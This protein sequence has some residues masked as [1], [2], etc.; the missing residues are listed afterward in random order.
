MPVSCPNCGNVAKF[1]RKY[2]GFEQILM[3]K[4]GK[5]VVTTDRK[6]RV[7]EIT[8]GECSYLEVPEKFGF[9]EEEGM[10]IPNRGWWV[11]AS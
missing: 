1:F 8:C 6:I 10:S 4:D 2:I 3:N 7:I 5:V 9:E 11:E